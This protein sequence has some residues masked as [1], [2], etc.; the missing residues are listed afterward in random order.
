MS[1]KP[2]PQKAKQQPL[3]GIPTPAPSPNPSPPSSLLK[4]LVG[5]PKIYEGQQVQQPSVIHPNRL[6]QGPS[7]IFV[8]Q[9]ISSSSYQPYV[10]AAQQQQ[11]QPLQPMKRIAYGAPML[12]P[13]PSFQPQSYMTQQQ[14]HPQQQSAQYI[15]FQNSKPESLIPRATMHPSASQPGFYQQQPQYNY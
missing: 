2:I 7:T 11:Q 4:P 15:H 10:P 13:P 3:K 12:A 8:T 6:N 1:A 14:P 9:P 5:P